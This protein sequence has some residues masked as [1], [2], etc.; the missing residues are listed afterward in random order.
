MNTIKMDLEQEV[1]VHCKTLYSINEYKCLIAF[2]HVN[3]SI[4]NMNTLDTYMVSEAV[5]SYQH[6]HLF[7]QPLP[8]SIPF[9]GLDH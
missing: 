6:Q 3:D 4:G 7:W 5:Y 2:K 9:Q 1:C 8:H